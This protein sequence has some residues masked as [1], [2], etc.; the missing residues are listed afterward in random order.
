M[1]EQNDP[2]EIN[3]ETCKRGHPR[4]EENTWR[5]PTTGRRTCRPCLR[6]NLRRWRAE[7]PERDKE[8]TA[9]SQAKRKARLAAEKGDRS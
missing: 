3:V 7:N 4:T 6:E 8:I 5:S 1:T 2:D 9:K